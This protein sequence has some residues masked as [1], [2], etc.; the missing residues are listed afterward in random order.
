MLENMEQLIS[1]FV[2]LN[3]TL[4]VGVMIQALIHNLNDVA[5]L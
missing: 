1:N 4:L 5:N 2:K 3:Q